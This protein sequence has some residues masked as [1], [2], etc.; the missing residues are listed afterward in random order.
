MKE[1]HGIEKKTR[2]K[3]FKLMIALILIIFSVSACKT[4]SGG[5]ILNETIKILQSS[6]GVSI[7]EIGA[8]F[9]QA[10]RIGSENVV[11]QLSAKNG[12]NND[13]T[14]HIP[15]P[16]KLETVK[17]TL[18]LIGLSGIVDDLELKLNRSAELATSKAK[19]LFWQ[20]ITEMTFN[21]IMDIYKGPEDS[22]TRYFKKKMSPGLISEMRPI[23]KNAL[24]KVGAIRVYD[25]VMGRYETL[26]F[27]PDIKADLT[28]HVVQRGMDGI[29]YYIAKE[30]AAIR[31][32]PV[33]QTTA[34]LKKVFGN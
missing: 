28:S 12:F 9:K 33:R 17:K 21:D 19:K 5:R 23:V 1:K 18:N 25:N 3:T 26:P 31:E 7:D 6:Q 16:E 13:S 32:D 8:A 14:I 20:S 4:S 30:E 27:M 15:L 24:S 22:A 34:L 2:T 11:S 10:L 29:F